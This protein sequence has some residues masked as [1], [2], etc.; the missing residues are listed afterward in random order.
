MIKCQAK[1]NSEMKSDN[2]PAGGSVYIS[3]H[4]YVTPC[5]WQGSLFSLKTI[6]KESELDPKLHNINYYSI[7]E[8]LDG[9]IF[10]WIEDQ[11]TASTSTV[12][13]RTCQKKCESGQYDKPNSI[14]QL[15]QI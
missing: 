9:P 14:I 3:H 13:L 2:L 11:W 6:W 12:T 8:I 4:G 1:Q 15:E 5:C 10:K 7:Q